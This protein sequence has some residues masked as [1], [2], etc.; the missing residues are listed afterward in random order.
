MDSIIQKI[1]NLLLDKTEKGSGEIYSYISDYR[2]YIIIGS[3]GYKYYYNASGD[4]DYDKTDYVFSLLLSKG[5]KVDFLFR[6][7]EAFSL[8][9]NKYK[10]KIMHGYLDF[11]NLGGT[12]N[13]DF[14]SLGNVNIIVEGEDELKFL[15]FNLSHLVDA[16]ENPFRAEPDRKVEFLYD[17]ENKKAI[18]LNIM[19]Y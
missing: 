2:T 13:K 9:Y 18:S 12:E 4:K 5:V 11:A 7:Q 19:R 17:L 16:S 14:M 10:Y 6:G 8:S 3:D 15:E 1:K